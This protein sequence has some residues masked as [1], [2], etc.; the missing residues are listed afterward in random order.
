MLLTPPVTLTVKAYDIRKGIPIDDPDGFEWPNKLTEDGNRSSLIRLKDNV[1]KGSTGVRGVAGVPRVAVPTRDAD[2]NATD[3]K[4]MVIPM[5]VRWRGN[6]TTAGTTGEKMQVWA[7]YADAAW[8]HAIDVPFADA[9]DSWYGS[10]DD[11][12]TPGHVAG[13]PLPVNLSHFRPTLENGEVV[14]RW[15]TESELDNAGFNILRSDTRTG[16]YKQVNAELIQGHGTTGE[17]STY[18]WVDASAKPGVVYYY[19]IEDVSFAGERQTLQT[20]KLKGYISAVG[21]ATTTWGDI[22]EVQ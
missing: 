3:S 10:R 21:K 5:D 13:T 20:T 22:K 1:V 11:E 19:Q 12:G 7:K 6:N 8:V 2:G 9:Q 4:G 14:I 18:K 15:T 17:R 16:E